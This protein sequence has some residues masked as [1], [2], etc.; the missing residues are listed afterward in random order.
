MKNLK[1]LGGFLLILGIA[2]GCSPSDS[3]TRIGT[4]PQLDSSLYLLASEPETSLGVREARQS[5]V[6]QD[7]IIV[8]GRIGGALNPWVDDRAAFQIVDTSLKAC[9]DDKPEGAHTSCPTPWDYC[10]ESDKLPTSMALVQFADQDGKVLRQDARSLF[11]VV[12][13]Q[14][15]VVQGMARRDDAGNLTIVA[16]RMFI[17]Q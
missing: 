5:V 17:R 10:C 14:T 13:L 3:E 12:E 15:V 6:D 1:V 2:I 4:G 8:V 16:D 9:S 7:E 11:D